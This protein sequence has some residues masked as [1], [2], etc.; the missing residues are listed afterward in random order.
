MKL[1]DRLKEWMGIRRLLRETPQDRKPIPRNLAMT[2][3]V[4][5]VYV[6]EDEAAHNHG[7]E[8]EAPEVLHVL[9]VD[10]SDRGA[11]HEPELH[12]GDRQCWPVRCRRHQRQR[13]ISRCAVR[14][15]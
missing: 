8:G 5:I 11:R 15:G 7:E 10:R 14:Y 4:A 1:F 2:R 6:V 3:K 13:R 12:A 9:G